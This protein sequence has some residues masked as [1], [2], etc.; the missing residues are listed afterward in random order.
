MSRRC[1]CGSCIFTVFTSGCNGMGLQ[2]VTVAVKSGGVTVATFTGSPGQSYVQ[3]NV[4]A[5][6]YDLVVSKSPRFNAKTLGNVTIACGGAVFV[7]LSTTSPGSAPVGVTVSGGG[8]ASGYACCQC[9]A[10]PLKTTL[11]A[12]DSVYGAYTLVYAGGATWAAQSPGLPGLIPQNP[13]AGCPTAPEPG[14]CSPLAAAQNTMGFAPGVGTS[15]YLDRQYG[16]I[17]RDVIPPNPQ[18]LCPAGGI[19]NTNNIVIP[20]TQTLLT[21]PDAGFIAVYTATDP[22]WY[23]G[24]TATITITE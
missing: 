7:D 10:D 16:A 11:N 5:G 24:A 13:Y 9:L 2:L 1:C 17:V 19:N 20:T 4:P 8:V 14:G 6:T 21:G 23:C 15:C 22:Y 12:T 18:H 3:I